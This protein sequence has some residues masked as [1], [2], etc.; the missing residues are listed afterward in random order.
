MDD[1]IIAEN[2]M[3][4]HHLSVRIRAVTTLNG[5]RIIERLTQAWA[6]IPENVLCI[7]AMDMIRSFTYWNDTALRSSAASEILKGRD[8]YGIV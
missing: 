1:H 4:N 6:V 2:D 7:L 8:E 5:P 3:E